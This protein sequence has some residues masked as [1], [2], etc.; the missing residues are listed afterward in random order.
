VG[1]DEWA[2]RRGHRDGTILVDLATHRVV[3]LLP[4]RSA[5]AVAAWRARHPAITVVS[6]DRSAL[7]ADGIRQGAPQ[8]VQVVD[9]FPLVEHLREAGEA[10][11]GPQRPALQAAAVRTAQALAA[12][13]DPVPGSPMSRGKRQCSQ[14]RQQRL[15]AEQP[16]RHAPW[17]TID[18]RIHT[19]HVPG[20]PM[21]AIA[22][23]LG[24]SRPTVYA[25]LRRDTPPPPRRPQR[26]GQVLTPYLRRRW[27]EGGTDSRPLWREIQAQ[28]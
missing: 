22:P 9:R 1:V 2:W 7:Y 11:L 26:T 28:G 21:A 5:V 15:T 16:Q 17:V 18:E 14:A 4:E 10:C 12:A 20:P 13:T 19:L 25:Y 23:Q 8:A 6:R 3:D 24:V 27:Q